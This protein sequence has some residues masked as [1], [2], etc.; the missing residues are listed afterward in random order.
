[1]EARRRVEAAGKAIAAARAEDVQQLAAAIASGGTVSPQA[2]RRAKEAEIEAGEALAMARAAHEQLETDLKDVER[3]AARADR[4]VRN[5]T[6]EVLK[7]TALQML[8]EA[9][10]FRAEFLRR[11]HAL[12]AMDIGGLE[13]LQLGVS[14][15]EYRQLCATVRQPW[16]DAIAALKRDADARLPG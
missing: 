1:M 16:L 9:K 12:D 11:Q 15:Q 4:G 6:A 5:A 14:E 10:H 8:E 13:R 2:T 3:E 7:P